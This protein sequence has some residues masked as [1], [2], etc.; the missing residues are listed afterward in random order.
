MCDCSAPA[1]PAPKQ[2][3]AERQAPDKWTTESWMRG[4]RR[5]AVPPPVRADATG[6]TAAACQMMTTHRQAASQPIAGRGRSSMDSIRAYLSPRASEQGEGRQAVK[7]NTWKRS[8][9]NATGGTDKAEREPWIKKVNTQMT[10]ESVIV[11]S[12]RSPTAGRGRKTPEQSPPVV[13]G[14]PGGEG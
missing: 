8:G 11:H 9:V 12:K 13:V 2:T 1:P 5:S 4:E 14:A 3:R 6:I 10:G 7:L